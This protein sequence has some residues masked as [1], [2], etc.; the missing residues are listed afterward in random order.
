MH[1]LIIF[2]NI[3]FFFDALLIR[4]CIFVCCRI[5]VATLQI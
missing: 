2:F 1:L 3:D 5:I 4:I